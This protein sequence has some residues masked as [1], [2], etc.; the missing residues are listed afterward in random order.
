VPVQMHDRP[1][2]RL[3]LDAVQRVIDREHVVIRQVVHPAHG[4]GLAAPRLERRAGILGVLA[5]ERRGRQVAMEL[6]PENL[7]RDQVERI[8]VEPAVGRDD[9]RNRQRVY[10]RPQADFRVRAPRAHEHAGTSQGDG[11]S[12]R[13]ASELQELAP[14]DRVS[15]LP[16]LRSGD[17]SRAEDVSTG[18]TPQNLFRGSERQIFPGAEHSSH[19]NE[20][21][22][23]IS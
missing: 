19:R 15:R 6:L 20:P 7:H 4:N 18:K 14:L 5:P 22:V 16:I 3:S 2:R 13:T 10:E 23:T 17:S 9:S 8:A 12:H 11:A 21:I 1:H